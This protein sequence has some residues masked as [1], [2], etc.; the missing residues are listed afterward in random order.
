MILESERLVF[1]FFENKDKKIL[2]ELLNNEN[3]SRLMDNIPFPYL[4]KHADW[5][6]EIGSKKKYQ[7][8]LIL[9]KSSALIGSL[10]ISLKGEIGCWIGAQYFNQSFATEAIERIKEFAFEELE[11]NKLW[12]STKE[13]NI[14]SFNLMKK[15]GFIRVEDKPYHVQGIGDTKVRPHFELVNRP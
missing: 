2:I 12:A 11:I 9:K 1:R 6:I 10:K 5:W 4:E 7:F 15:T 3:V 8:A 14:A 13:N